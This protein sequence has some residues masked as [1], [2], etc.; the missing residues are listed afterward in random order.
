VCDD[1][2]VLNPGNPNLSVCLRRADLFHNGNYLKSFCI[3]NET[4]QYWAADEICRTNRMNLF[5]IDDA[6]TQFEFR[7]TVR[8]VMGNETQN[9]F[10]INGNVDARCDNIWYSFIPW[11]IRLPNFIHWVQEREF[12]GIHTGPCLRYTQQFSPDYYAMGMDCRESSW[13]ACEFSV[14]P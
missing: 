12:V 5:I 14:P 6:D 2:T 7:N 8:Q 11:P 3:I 1:R 13:M 9:F 10:W 4:V